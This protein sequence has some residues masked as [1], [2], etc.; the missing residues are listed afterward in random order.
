MSQVQWSA[1]SGVR[2]FGQVQP[3]VC[4]KRRKVCSMSNHR[5]YACQRRSTSAGTGPVYDL[6]QRRQWDGTCAR[7]DPLA[8]L[9][10]PGRRRPSPR[11]AGRTSL[12]GELQPARNPRTRDRTAARLIDHPPC[13]PASPVRR[14]RYGHGPAVPPRCTRAIPR[15]P[16]LRHPA[17]IPLRRPPH[18]H[19]LLRPLL[20][21]P[22]PAHQPNHRACTP[23]WKR[24][25]AE[26]RQ[27]DSRYWPV[28][29]TSSAMRAQ[30][31]SL[32][33]A[34]TF[35]VAPGVPTAVYP[36][37]KHRVAARCHG[38]HTT[39]PH[40]RVAQDA[41]VQHASPAVRAPGA[42][43]VSAVRAAGGDGRWSRAT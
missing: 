42:G 2:I 12:E 37:V 27:V 15:R 29:L 31:A 8:G 39:E 21:V 24:L 5:R 13:S 40:S 38:L 26:H 6:F 16:P 32:L 33:W 28:R 10:R 22:S 9:P 17:C 4:L 11:P 35:D 19:R 36:M 23:G 1:A 41:A 43:E 7:D 30:D 34:V 25:I 18:D 20:A 3:R 14:D